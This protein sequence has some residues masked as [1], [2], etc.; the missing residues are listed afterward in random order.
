MGCFNVM[1]TVVFLGR[2]LS[3]PDIPVQHNGPP[4]LALVIDVV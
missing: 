2:L 3:L 1:H 4:L